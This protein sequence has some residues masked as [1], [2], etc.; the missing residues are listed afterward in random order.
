MAKKSSVDAKIK[1]EQD[2]LEQLLANLPKNPVEWGSIIR[3]LGPV[4]AR[5]AVRI[6]LKRAKRSMAESKVNS[7]ADSI[8]TTISTLLAS[9][10]C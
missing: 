5:L 10:E 2:S 3:I 8:S 9:K 1:R 4:I 6:A 7:V